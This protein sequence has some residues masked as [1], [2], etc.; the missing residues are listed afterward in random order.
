MQIF[1]YPFISK[2]IYRYGNFPAS[3]FLLSILYDSVSNLNISLFNLIPFLITLLLLYYMN[4]HY[5]MLYKIIPSKIEADAEKMVCSGFIFSRKSLTIFYSDIESLSG[6]IF[7]GKNYGIMKVC[8]GKSKVCIGFF[9]SLK[10]VRNLEKIILAKVNKDIYEK[11]A[12]KIKAMK[13]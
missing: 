11:S 4:K 6:G 9:N 12:E 7:D 8:D 2:L 3:I 1:T 5:L 10:N 13:K